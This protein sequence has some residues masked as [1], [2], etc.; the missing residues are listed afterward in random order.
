MASS[1]NNPIVGDV[2]L[3]EYIIGEKEKSKIGRSKY[4]ERKK[5]FEIIQLTKDDKFKILLTH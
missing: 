1:G 4:G 2:P 3:N 5:A